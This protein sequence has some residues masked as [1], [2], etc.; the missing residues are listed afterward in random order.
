MVS[1]VVSSSYGFIVEVSARFKWNFKNESLISS[2]SDLQLFI[3][4]KC[5]AELPN[6]APVFDKLPIHIPLGYDSVRWG[7]NL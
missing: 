2:V 6:H 5:Y 7:M 1:L 3:M 4:M